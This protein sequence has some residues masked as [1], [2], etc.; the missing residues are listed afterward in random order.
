M[1]KF[2]STLLH[3]RLE[4]EV[5]KNKILSQSQAGFRKSYRITDHIKTLFT[6]IKK[7]IREGNY[8]YTCFVDFRK[9]YGSIRIQ[10]LIYKLKVFVLTSNILEII[11][12]MYTTLKVSL[13]YKGR[14]SHSFS[15]KT[16]LKQGDVLSTLL[17]NLYTNDLLDILNEGSNSKEEQLHI[18]KLDNVTINNL[19]S[20]D[21]LSIVSWSKYDLQKKISNLE[22]Y[23]EK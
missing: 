8:L 6:L 21:D 23:C 15:A 9:A 12:T 19:L 20:P 13:L 16:G 18:P 14:I 10:M 3:D 17:F 2:F 5:E 11:K 4:N 22:N 7:S 1:G